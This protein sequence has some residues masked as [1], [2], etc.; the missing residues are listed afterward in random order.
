VSRIAQLEE[1]LREDP[2]DDFNL[3]ALALEYLKSDQ[4]KAHDLFSNLLRKSPG[5]LPTYYP[6]AHLLIEL[7]QATKAE[8]IFEQGIE[9][10]RRSGDSKT[11]KELTNAYNDWLFE[12]S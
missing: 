2:D 9:L 4:L 7:Q 3:Y 10:A 5:Y 12:R 8:E 6:F 11:L 1:F